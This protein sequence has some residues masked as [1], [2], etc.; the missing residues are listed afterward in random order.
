MSQTGCE[1]SG[2]D[3]YRQ[4]FRGILLP[5]II[6]LAIVLL[7]TPEGLSV[8]GQKAIALMAAAVF[9]WIAEPIAV[10]LSTPFFVLLQ[11]PL[12]L[13]NLPDAMQS[14]TGP[15]FI[16]LFIM[17]CL[18]AAMKNSG[19]THRIAL[20]ATLKANGS[21]KRLIV[22]FVFLSSFVSTIVADMPVAVMLLPVCLAVLE[23]N[24]VDIKGS[25]FGSSLLIGVAMAS[26]LGGIGTPAGS[27]MNM[28]VIQLLSNNANMNISFMEWSAL[29]MPMVILL[30][31]VIAWACCYLVPS[32]IKELKGM[33][34][35]KKEY[36]ALGPL[37]P[38]EIKFFVIFGINII[39]WYTDKLHHIPMQVISMIA[40]AAFALPG[41]DIFN[42][43]RDGKDINW[44]PIM[45]VGGSVGLATTLWK[46]GAAS[47]ISDN[48]LGIFAS[49]PLVVLLA[50]LAVFTMVI[51][52]LV[53]AS[54]AVVAVLG[55]PLLA[56][57]VKQG[58]PPASLVVALGICSSASMLTPIN[59][60]YLILCKSG[61]ARVKD[62]YTLGIPVC[63]AW[64]IVLVVVMYVIGRPLGFI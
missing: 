61:Y 54:S 35:I 41:I 63:I 28:L 16:F 25:N 36:E 59:P 23:K 40:V 24:E 48:F 4:L 19:F 29:G 56:L 2:K 43:K 42:W 32:E 27:A 9:V 44:D 55:A 58:L 34:E 17:F 8:Q 64:V 22:F 18:A 10:T 13:C 39:L 33:E 20:Y 26:L 51:Q 50:V 31:P 5:F 6:Y 46:T 62:M 47:Y 21:P 15:L 52:L 11:V 12:G 30:T 49:M 38:K 60:N 53:P 14:F 7:P 37:T 57:A 1:S 45:L 3:L